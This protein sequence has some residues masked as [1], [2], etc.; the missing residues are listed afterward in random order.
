MAY[1]PDCHE[2]EDVVK[3]E[4]QAPP[5]VVPQADGFA[6]GRRRKGLWRWRRLVP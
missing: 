6:N 1:R 2:L 3:T 4:L 5:V